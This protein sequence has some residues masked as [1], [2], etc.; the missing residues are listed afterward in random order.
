MIAVL[1]LFA[2]AAFLSWA[3]TPWMR[4]LALRVGLLDHPG[5]RK[6]QREPVPCLGG[7]AVFFAFAIVVGGGLAVLMLAPGL[8]ARLGAPLLHGEREMAL[9]KLGQILTLLSGCAL[10][11][12]VGLLDDKL[13]AR[14][15]PWVKLLV[16]A[17]AAALAVWAGAVTSVFPWPWLNALISAVWIVAIT[18]ALNFVDNMDGLSAGLA[19]ISSLLLGALAYQQDQYFMLAIFC[20]LSGAAAGFL[21]WNFPRARIYLGDAGSLFLGY[22]LG[23]LTLLESYVTP[24]SH[25]LLPILLPILVLTVPV[26]DMVSVIVIRLRE[27][28]PIYVGDRSHLS[29][30]LVARGLPPPLAV[31]FLYLVAAGL[32]LGAL[33]LPGLDLTESIFLLAQW[34]VSLALI[35]ILLV[36]GRQGEG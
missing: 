34:L 17:A 20:A 15:S 29:H 25:T 22:C 7:L 28:R 6:D 12:G 1:F 19:A 36:V 9:A 18:N 33:L 31:L 13:G 14:L 2:A 27:G 30:R 11:V 23:A 8:A 35:S 10:C 3:A 26:F 4:R 21:P 16:Q 32:G 5:P 24:A